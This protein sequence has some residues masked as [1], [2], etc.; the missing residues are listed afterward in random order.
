MLYSK[1]VIYNC[2]L[3]REERKGR[4]N[5]LEEISGK[6]F[7]KFNIND[8]PTRSRRLMEPKQKENEASHTYKGTL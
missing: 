7:F 5:I 8:K 3:R 1:V 2:S 6:I 4:K